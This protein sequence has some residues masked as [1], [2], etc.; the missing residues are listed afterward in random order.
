MHIVAFILFSLAFAAAIETMRR[1]IAANGSRILDAL[2]GVAP[3][4]VEIPTEGAARVLPFKP[5][6]IR[7]AFQLPERLAA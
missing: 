6:V 2:A 5:V 7:P 3:E 1:T 4:V